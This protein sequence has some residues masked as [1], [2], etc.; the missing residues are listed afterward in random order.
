M[1]ANMPWLTMTP[2]LGCEPSTYK[3]AMPDGSFLAQSVLALLND[4]P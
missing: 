2:I 1:T 3:R 4:S